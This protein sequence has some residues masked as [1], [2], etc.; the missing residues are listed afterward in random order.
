[1]VGRDKRDSVTSV[2]SKNANDYAAF[3]DRDGLRGARIGVARQYFG[4]NA[5]LKKLIEAQIEILREAGANLIEVNFAEDYSK[6]GDDRLNVLLYEFKTDL[7]LYLKNRGSK[8]KT[9]DDLIKFNEANKEK[10][11]RLFAQELFVQSQEK[12]SLTDKA[13]LDSLAKVKTV[14]RENG[15]DLVV[16]KNKLDGIVSFA[17][18]ATWSIS[19]V[20]G[21][22]YITVP[23]GM[24]E[25]LPF[26]LG[27]F[28]KAFTEPQ[29]IK[30]AYAYEQKSEARR[31]PGFIPASK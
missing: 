17:S 14:T 12:G 27:F 18:G 28:G 20:A 4:N 3:L 8:Y 2:A 26:G 29:L 7:N 19:A 16:E 22:P 9:L 31:K 21:Y 6:L 24:Y 10:E 1:M 25:G 13:Y 15:I 30:F 23:A 11:M 5:E